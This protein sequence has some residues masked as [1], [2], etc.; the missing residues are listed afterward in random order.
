MTQ[1]VLEMT[2]AAATTTPTPTAPRTARSVVATVDANTF[3]GTTFFALTP[4]KIGNRMKIKDPNA[5]RAYLDQLANEV[6]A[7]KANGQAVSTELAATTQI[8]PGNRTG[9]DY[10]K[11]AAKATKQ[12]L[13][14]PALEALNTYLST[15][16]DMLTGKFGKAQQSRVMKGLYV[17][18]DTYTE[19]YEQAIAETN[20]R[21]KGYWTNPDGSRGAD[22]TDAKGQPE[23]GLLPAF[24]GDYEKAIE[25]TR[26]L[27][28]LEGG[29]GP[30]FNA[31]DYPATGEAF[32]GDVRLSRFWAKLGVADNLPPALKAQCMA[33]YKAKCADAADECKQAMRVALGGFLDNLVEKFSPGEDA[34]KPRIFRDTILENIR[35]FCAVFDAKNFMGDEELAAQVDAC[36][37]ILQDP[38]LTPE[39]CRKYSSVRENT[40]A[41]FEKI[42]TALDSMTVATG[43]RAIDL[44]DE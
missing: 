31:T 38:N 40:R 13:V 20:A 25:R 22:W 21:I 12:L 18:K 43:D 19:E 6:A 42:K 9:A 23:D 37:K 14:S 26:D 7:K 36:K 5:Y 2:A 30:L 15:R 41:Q 10:S 3:F 27:P 39:N 44:S 32:A 35:Q 28:L 24:L 17:V 4:H 16:K 8:Q 33:E 29:L 11:L 34:K 1:A